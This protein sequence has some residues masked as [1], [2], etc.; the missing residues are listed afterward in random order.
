[1]YEFIKFSLPC[2]VHTCAHFPDEETD[3]ERPHNSHKATQFVAMS[4]EELRV[5]VWVC[6]C[7]CKC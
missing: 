6:V 2:T 5:F 7:A 3:S 1:M 4:D